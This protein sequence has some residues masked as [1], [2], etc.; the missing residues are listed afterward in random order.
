MPKV[1]IKW[2]VIAD[3]MSLLVGGMKIM[4]MSLMS[5]S[6]KLRLGVWQTVTEACMFGG[7]IRML[8][9][10]EPSTARRNRLQL[11]YLPCGSGPSSWHVRRHLCHQA[12]SR[13]HRHE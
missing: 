10:E 5:R 1:Y 12:G 7:S 8:H 11:R 13:G 9:R 6:G 2:P 4:I 3:Y